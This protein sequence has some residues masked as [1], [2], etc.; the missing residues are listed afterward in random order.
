MEGITTTHLL[1]AGMGVM[2][3]VVTFLW[4]MSENDRKNR[5]LQTQK[6]LG[7]VRVDAHQSRERH[8]ECE[9]NYSHILGQMEIIKLLTCGFRK[10]I[11]EEEARKLS[12]MK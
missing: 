5:E 11:T 7:E 3:T 1:M 10:P 6:E 4:R 9:K 12:E 8:R 2:A